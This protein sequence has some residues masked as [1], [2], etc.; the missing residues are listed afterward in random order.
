MAECWHNAAFSPISPLSRK[1]H[2]RQAACRHTRRRRLHPR[3]RHQGQYDFAALIAACPALKPHVKPNPHGLPSID[4]ANPQAVK[5]LNRALLA[6]QY[7]VQQWDIPP[8]YLCPPIPGVPITFMPWPT[9]WP[10]QGAVPHGSQIRLLDIGTGANLVYPL[11]AHAEYGWDCVGSD[12]D[13]PALDNAQTILQANPAFAAHIALRHQT[14]DDAMFSGIWQKGERFDLTLCNPPFHASRAAAAAGSE[15]KWRNLGKGKPQA[16]Q[17]APALNFGGRDRELC[18][19][20]GEVAFVSRM[21]EDSAVLPGSACGLPAWCPVPTACPP[22]RP[23]CA[24][25]A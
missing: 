12:I 11:L 17:R 4:F 16:G 2:D 3:N 23:P 8:G 19:P 18:Y 24:M 21:I 5:L 25:P 9:C 6:Q 22:C 15:R 10:G 7:G 13:R 1:P 14:R 20:G